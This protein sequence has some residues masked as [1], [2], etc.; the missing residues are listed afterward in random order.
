MYPIRTTLLTVSRTIKGGSPRFIPPSFTFRIPAHKSPQF[1]L[2]RL[3]SSFESVVHDKNRVKLLLRLPLFSSFR[4]LPFSTW[5]LILDIN[6]ELLSLRIRT[7]ASVSCG[8]I[9]ILCP[10]CAQQTR[11]YSSPTT[12]KRSRGF[13]SKCTALAIQSPTISS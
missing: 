11:L 6:A 4:L 12:T 2:T 9:S 10:A 13:L 1:L 8:I 5:L 3:Q 7:L